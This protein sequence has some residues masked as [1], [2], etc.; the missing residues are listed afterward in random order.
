MVVFSTINRSN[1]LPQRTADALYT[2]YAKHFFASIKSFL[3]LS[4]ISF[5]SSFN[6]GSGHNLSATDFHTNVCS[7]SSNTTLLRPINTLKQIGQSATI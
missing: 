5:G 7:K 6:S 2:S 3:A 4:G 1:D